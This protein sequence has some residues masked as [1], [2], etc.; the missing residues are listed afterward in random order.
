[1]LWRYLRNVPTQRDY[2]SIFI[3]V[4]LHVCYREML[5]IKYICGKSREKCS[6]VQFYFFHREREKGIWCVVFQVDDYAWKSR[7]MRWICLYWPAFGLAF[8]FSWEVKKGRCHTRIDMNLITER[9][10]FF[11]GRSRERPRENTGMAVAVFFLLSW[12]KDSTRNDG[13]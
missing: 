5:T 9:H 7:K 2:R 12:V 8:C 3:V 6:R 1:M 10:E 11:S 4:C 13:K